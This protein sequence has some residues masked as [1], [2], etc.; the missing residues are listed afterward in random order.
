MTEEELEQRATELKYLSHVIRNGTASI[1]GLMLKIEGTL[2]GMTEALNEC[3]REKSCP[4]D[5]ND[6]GRP[7]V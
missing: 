1:A 7:N 3:R 5:E 4:S 2:T 6:D